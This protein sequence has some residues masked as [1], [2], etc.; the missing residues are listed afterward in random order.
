MI[1]PS[2]AFTVAPFRVS[3]P[4]RGLIRV[5][6]PEAASFLQGIVSN[7]LALLETR[8]C[9]YA[10][11][12]TPQGKFLH[13]FLISREGN[14]YLLDCEG[15]PRAEDLRQ[16]LERYKLR[17][18]VTFAVQT[19]IS[20]FV[21]EVEGNAD[22]RHPALGNR[23]FLK[24]KGHLDPFSAWDECRLRLGVPDG[25]R[26]AVIDDSTLD[27]LNLTETAVSF[28]KGCYIG[29]ELTARMKLRGLGKKHLR[30]VGFR[31]DPPPP[32]GVLLHLA[33]GREIGEMRS[34]CGQ[35]GLAL[36]RDDAVETLGK[37]DGKSPLYLLG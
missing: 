28:S 9:L 24:P 32:R 18:P 22:P 16:R 8:P 25:S 6:G 30:P 21:G 36:L 37:D 19:E 27:E 29:Q 11:L 33:D 5:G 34:S 2:M 4:G 15:G 12:L 13:D 3:L 14:D 26:D 23:S 1:E 31:S 7:D 35:I 17:A 10:C 20:V